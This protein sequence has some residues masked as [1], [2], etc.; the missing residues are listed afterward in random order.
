MEKEVCSGGEV[1]TNCAPVGV[2]STVP[3]SPVAGA[4]E[5]GAG[6]SIEGGGACRLKL[7]CSASTRDDLF[8]KELPL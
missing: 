1:C 5:N 3:D 4:F 7:R 6:I 8:A 2:I